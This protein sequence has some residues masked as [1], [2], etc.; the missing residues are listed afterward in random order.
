MMG[1]GALFL[2]SQHLL[3]IVSNQLLKFVD[4]ICQEVPEM[5]E[6]SCSWHHSSCKCAL[7][8]WTCESERTIE[9]S[10]LQWKQPDWF[11]HWAPQM[12]CQHGN[13]QQVSSCDVLT[14]SGN[15]FASSLILSSSFHL[16][17]LFC[18]TWHELLILKSVSRCCNIPVWWTL[19]L[20]MPKQSRHVWEGPLLPPFP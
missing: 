17:T 12:Y 7:M 3:I 8:L 19:T 15:S 18:R 2:P 14:L 16:H 1:S 4:G 6:I 5:A 20:F 10:Q 13:G 11:T 9:S